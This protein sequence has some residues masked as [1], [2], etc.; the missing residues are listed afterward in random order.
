MMLMRL[1]GCRLSV[2]PCDAIGLG[3]FF[4][5]ND[6]EFDLVPFLEALIAVQ[7]NG[8]IV[9]EYIGTIF[10]PDEPISLGVVEPLHFSLVL[11]H[12]ART[13]L[14]ERRAVCLQAHNSHSTPTKQTSRKGFR[15]SQGL[16]FCVSRERARRGEVYKIAQKLMRSM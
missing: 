4:A 14:R 2:E 7:L 12:E 15:F 10:P 13:F 3:A 1:F 11:R 6:V 16:L 9:H 5:L 8:A